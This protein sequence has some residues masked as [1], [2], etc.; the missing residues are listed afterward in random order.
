MRCLKTGL[1]IAIPLFLFPEA[2]SFGYN[3]PSRLCRPI[4]SSFLFFFVIHASCAQYRTGA[5]RLF[6]ASAAAMSPRKI[7]ILIDGEWKESEGPYNVEVWRCVRARARVCVCVCVHVIGL[8]F[9]PRG[10]RGV[11]KKKKEK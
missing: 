6:S 5:T 4:R 10:R 3:R 9:E 11:G 8:T 2:T 7:K 1:A